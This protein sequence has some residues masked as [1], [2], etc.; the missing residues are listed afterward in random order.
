MTSAW[1]WTLRPVAVSSSKKWRMFSAMRCCESVRAGV[2]RRRLTAHRVQVGLALL[3][4]TVGLGVEPLEA[5]VLVVKGLVDLR[6]SG[7]PRTVFSTM[8]VRCMIWEGE[9]A[10]GYGDARA[11]DALLEALPTV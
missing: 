3:L 6:V 11:T 7:G 8:P 1:R 2:R 4:Q 10:R 5:H 9:T